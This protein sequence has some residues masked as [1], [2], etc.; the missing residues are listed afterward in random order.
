MYRS[1]RPANSLALTAALAAVASVSTA[2][3]PQPHEGAAPASPGSV[4]V[5]SIMRRSHGVQRADGALRGAGP[6]FKVRF[7][8]GGLEYVPALGSGADRNYPLSFRLES[9]HRGSVE[10]ARGSDAAPTERGNAVE[11]LHA[12]GV[13]ERY[14]VR[15]EGVAQSFT[16]PSRPAGSGELVVRGRIETD[17]VPD[18]LGESPAGF[19]FELPG[20]GAVSYGGVTGISAD[21]READGTLRLDGGAIE[22]VLPAEFVDG[23]AYPM[24][25]DPLIGTDILINGFTDEKDPD[26][27]YDA[28]NDL[29]L[30]VWE[31]VFSATDFDIRGQR[32]DALGGLISGPI[33]IESSVS[34]VASNPAVANINLRDAFVVCYESSGDVLARGVAAA[35]G[36]LTNQITVAG[37]SAFERDVDVGGDSA[38]FDD[39]VLAVWTAF[40][41]GS[42]SIMAAQVSISAAFNLFTFDLTQIG[43]G[44]DEV[45][46]ISESGG[47]DG[48]Y[49]IVWERDFTVDHDIQA[50][51]VDRN[52]T[53]L[54]EVTIITSVGPDERR[55]ACDGDGTEWIV[56]YE[57][58]EPGGP[59]SSDDIVA[60]AVTFDAAAS[61]ASVTTP[62]VVV[63]GDAN[64]DEQRPSV[65]C[66]GDS[67][68]IGFED[69]GFAFADFDAFVAS[70]QSL[71]CL[72]CEGTFSLSSGSGQ[73][74][75]FVEVASRFSGD[76]SLRDGAL[77]VW[78]EELFSTL[79]SEI[80]A[81]LYEAEDGF[82]ADL[83]GGCG[84]GGRALAS[85]AAV[86]NDD[87]SVHLRDAGSFLPAFLLLS[88]NE[89]RIG[90]GSCELIPDLVD[91]V[92]IDAGTTTGSGRAQIDIAIPNDSAL[93]GLTLLGQW[94][95]T[96]SSGPVCTLLN[97]DL[98]NAISIELE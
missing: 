24:V 27:A 95:V 5:P 94:A 74:E 35:T 26:V 76:S 13:V 51:V 75:A 53:L 93:S 63:E 96:P 6:D 41:N 90:C 44:D 72:T 58:D 70:V 46:S 30:D 23:A 39:D 1:R 9:I 47:A 32:V 54:D 10:L 8:E 89:L 86:G 52:L 84:E 85:C 22:L 16:F 88:P 81:R 4:E 31:R 49:L 83:G 48:R 17:L 60:R 15:P 14:D 21:G 98:S 45:P 78:E 82:F 91:G 77:L 87:F 2:Q 66:L 69:E 19:R 57:K 3:A 65:A 64:E 67:Y 71:D 59:T 12:G 62:E 37:T 50:A 97:V 18:R 42:G 25:L 92:V 80:H 38:L 28:T 61:L 68:L 73:I 34:L 56:A 20:V 33:L 7:D 29:Y 36:N 40:E 11:Y 79:D 43:N 55:P